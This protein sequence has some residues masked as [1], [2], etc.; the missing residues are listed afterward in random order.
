MDNSN[1]RYITWK[2]ER[3]QIS[4]IVDEYPNIVIYIGE[5]YNGPTPE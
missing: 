5:V 3:W 4:T 2:G 1:I